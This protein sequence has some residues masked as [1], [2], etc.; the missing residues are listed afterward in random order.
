M[1]IHLLEVKPQASKP[2][3]K[4][5]DWKK[6]IPASMGFIV[7]CRVSI[8]ALSSDMFCPYLGGYVVVFEAGCL[9]AGWHALHHPVMQGCAPPFVT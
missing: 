4:Y 2:P 6:Q 3:W 1:K 7:V 9:R 8:L 5:I